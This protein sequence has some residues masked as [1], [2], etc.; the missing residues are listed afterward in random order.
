MIEDKYASTD[1]FKKV[2]ELKN[3]FSYMYFDI[4]RGRL[5]DNLTWTDNIF[6][7]NDFLLLYDSPVY[8]E[9]GLKFEEASKSEVGEAFMLTVMEL[10]GTIEDFVN[11]VTADEN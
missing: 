2:I 9:L 3:L 11:E 10:F 5:C 4:T 8:R 6:T 7:V 1:R